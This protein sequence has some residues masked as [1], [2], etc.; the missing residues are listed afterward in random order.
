MT[1]SDANG[2][3]K[4]ILYIQ[5]VLEHKKLP[6]IHGELVGIKSFA[7]HVPSL[8]IMATKD[9]TEWPMLEMSNRI[10]TPMVEAPNMNPTK[11]DEN[12]SIEKPNAI[13]EMFIYG[14]KNVILYG[15]KRG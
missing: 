15:E 9:K 5:G 14:D 12:G 4:V 3:F 11:I 1:Q 10:F 13:N 7:K 8:K 6:P 2:I